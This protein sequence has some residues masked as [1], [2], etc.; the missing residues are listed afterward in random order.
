MFALGCTL[1]DVALAGLL[2]GLGRE[3]Y[4]HTP[5]HSRNERY[6]L[7]PSLKIDDCDIALTILAYVENFLAS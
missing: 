3:V 2:A 6:H 4:F 7:S 1:R 5:Q